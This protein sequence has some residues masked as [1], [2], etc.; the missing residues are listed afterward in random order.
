MEV[1]SDHEH[2]TFHE[3]YLATDVAA[4]ALGEEWRGYV[5]WIC[6]EK[7]KQGFPMKQGILTFVRV[8]LLL[9]KGYSCCSQGE[10][11]KE[12][13]N[14]FRDALYVVVGYFDHTLYTPGTDNNV[15]LELK[16]RDSC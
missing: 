1:D 4:D 3:K 6:E 2:C 9:I 5:V 14:L 8:H 13:P 12:S 15:Y 10:L 11:E 7:D 16:G